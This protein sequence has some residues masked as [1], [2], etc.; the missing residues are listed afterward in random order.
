M[1]RFVCSVVAAVMAA[2]LIIAC[3]GEHAPRFEF[4]HQ[5]ERQ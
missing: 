4:N 2:G 5:G 3:L 1:I